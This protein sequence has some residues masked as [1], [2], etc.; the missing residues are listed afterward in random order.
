MERSAGKCVDEGMIRA[1]VAFALLTLGVGL[2]CTKP[3]PGPKAGAAPAPVEDAKVS[4]RK[5]T[6]IA[7][8]MQ[9]SCALAD[10]GR[11]FC[12]GRND[13]GQLG[14]KSTESCS[15]LDIHGMP[16]APVPCRDKPEAVDGLADVVEIAVGGD[17]G[18]ARLANGTV[19]CWGANGNGMIGDGTT[20]DRPAATPIPAMT[21]VVQI[22]VSTT[23]ACARHE[24]GSLD[25]WGQNFHGELGTVPVQPPPGAVEKLG[26][27]AVKVPSPQIVPGLTDVV[28]VAVG[29]EIT[30]AKKKNGDVFCFGVMA[31]ATLAQITPTIMPALHGASALSLGIATHCGLFADGSAKCWGASATAPFQPGSKHEKTP[32]SGTAIAG[33]AAIALGANRACDVV[34]PGDVLCWGDDSSAG[35]KTPQKIALAIQATSVSMGANHACALGTD[36]SVWCWGDSFF[37]Q[38]AA[39]VKGQGA[40]TSAFWTIANQ[41]SLR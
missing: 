1:R 24:D 2:A 6:A 32:V 25:C 21:H 14:S 36:G 38:A 30:C 4:G 11:V 5:A 8:G 16:P 15:V 41:V 31:P 22:A 3:E 33:A 28:L 39:P 13:H 10:D 40:P 9:H 7:V 17:T 18:C 26:Y 27:G 20:T 34:K 12:W 23:H 19:R 35:Q 37:G 29:D